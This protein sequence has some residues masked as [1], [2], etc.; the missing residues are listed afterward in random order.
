LHQIFDLHIC[1]NSFLD[2]SWGNEH[3]NKTLFYGFFAPLLQVSRAYPSAK[4]VNEHGS[5]REKLILGV[6]YDCLQAYPQLLLDYSV[7]DKGAQGIAAFE[8]I[9]KKIFSKE[10]VAPYQKINQ[11]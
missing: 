4:L 5:E 6:L 2:N 1:G 9:N 8:P 11:R 7:N 10:E 3:E